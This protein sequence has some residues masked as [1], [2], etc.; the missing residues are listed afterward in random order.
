MPILNLRPARQGSNG[1]LSDHRT[2]PILVSR[3]A[4]VSN[5]M[6]SQEA[7]RGRKRNQLVRELGN[8]MSFV[9]QT[10]ELD[11]SAK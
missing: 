3:G 10:E 4:G 9:F 7:Y 11:G 6:P 2:E 5:E 8:L 1:T